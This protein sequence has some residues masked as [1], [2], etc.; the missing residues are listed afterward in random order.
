M[1]LV[2]TLR[3]L[4]STSPE[5]LNRYNPNRPLL[6]DGSLSEVVTQALNVAYSKKNMTSGEPNYGHQNATGNPP[7]GAGNIPNILKPDTPRQDPIRPSLESMQQMQSAE[8]DQVA[9]V[10]SDAFNAKD[11]NASSQLKTDPLLIYAIP[12]DNMVS[13]EMNAD[14]DMYGNSGAI[15]PGDFVFVYTDSSDTVG[16]I[17]YRVVSMDQKIKDYEG[18]GARVYPDLQSFIADLDNIRKK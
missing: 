11:A 2:A 3:E 16:D 14:I 12:S 6:V 13:E 18:K 15:D 4:Q 17:D 9:A 5:E 1:T 10:L 8:V 7:P